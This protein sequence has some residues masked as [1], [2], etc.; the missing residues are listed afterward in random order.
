MQAAHPSPPERAPH[1][2]RALVFA[3]IAVLTALAGLT[4]IPS[5][6]HAADGDVVTIPDP[7][8]KAAANVALGG[9]RPA[10]Q[11]ITVSEAK[12][13]NALRIE[14]QLADLAGLQAFTNLTSIQAVNNPNPV[15]DLTPLSGLTHL[16]NLDVPFAQIQNLAPLAGVTSLTTLNLFLDQVRDLTPL[17][18]LTQLQVIDL[19]GNRVVDVSPLGALTGLTFVNLQNNQIADIGGLPTMRS[20]TNLV[21]NDNKITDVASLAGKVD[22]SVL[23][24]LN[25]RNNRITDASA[26]APLGEA[27]G[28]LASASSLSDGI[29]LAGN[30]IADFSAF[31]SWATPPTS[32]RLSEQQVYV[33]AYQV[34]GVHV[35]LKSAVATSLP[36]VSPATAGSFDASTGTLTVTDPSAT[37][38]TVSPNW[39]VFFSEPPTDVT[40][41]GTPQVGKLLQPTVPAGQSVCPGASYEWLRD[42]DPITAVDYFNSGTVSGSAQTGSSGEQT[43]YRASA[44]DVGHELTVQLICPDTGPTTMSVPVLITAE[45]AEKPVVQSLQGATSYAVAGS[46]AWTLSGVV[47]DPTNPTLP[48]YVAQLDA[49]STL[50]PSSQLTVTASVTP[51]NGAVKDQDVH[52]NGTGSER[53]VVVDPEA[54]TGA[55]TVTVMLTVHG[56]SGK[57]TTLTFPYKA[58]MATT[59]TSRVLL[60]SSDASTVDR[61]RGRL[62]DGRR[63]RE[64]RH[65][66]CTTPRTRAARSGSSR[67]RPQG[68]QR[69]RLRVLGP[70]G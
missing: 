55:S 30:R 65:P 5:A 23:T 60:G 10:D 51:A 64:P 15:S 11:D 26:L 18:G 2:L 48:I 31:S 32:D 37:S 28:K 42:N 39:T 7:S 13:V 8:V 50:V 19:T 40:I 38:V 25:L 69:D 12:T 20:A 58:S 33:G 6:A 66:A 62:P 43:S 45:E 3:L 27:G 4:I 41:D 52:V 68:W 47:G 35:P 63:R 56:T 17:Q 67:R 54:P 24:V 22:K 14:G 53:T 29:T 1:P 57:T 49:S 34:G 16:S 46:T 59:P 70:Q 9:G 36:A 21:L 44:A 61:G